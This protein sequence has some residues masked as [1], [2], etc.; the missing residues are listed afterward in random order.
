M[1]ERVNWNGDLVIIGGGA[2]GLA[3]AISAKMGAPQCRIALIEKNSVF[4]KKLRITGNGRGNISNSHILTAPETVAFFHCIAIMTRTD[5]AG[6]IYPFSESAAEMTDV[7]VRQAEILGCELY[8]DTLVQKV[9]ANQEGFVIQTENIDFKSSKLIIATGGKAGIPSGE[10]QKIQGRDGYFFAAELGHKL[11]KTTPVLTGVEIEDMPEILSGIRVKGEVRLMLK[12]QVEP[13]FTEKG[14]IQFT[15]YGLSGICIFNL[16]RYLKY[17]EDKKL[18]PYLILIDLDPEHEAETF[19]TNSRRYSLCCQKT[20]KEILDGC[21]KQQIV[22]VLLQQANTNEDAV[23]GNLSD[24]AFSGLI[25]TMHHFCF[26]PKATKGFRMAQCTAG[27]VSLEDLDPLNGASKRIPG[28]YIVGE[29]M[30][31]DGPCG[32]YNLDHAFSTGRL[33]GLDA[34]S[35]LRRMA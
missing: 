21:F 19:F 30:D 17:I 8:P 29:L 26:Q 16:S 6:R 13:L 3:A 31:Y 1:A 24:E 27:G 12:G 9:E 32:G 25:K 10:R 5:S 11:V 20:L 7:M 14:E 33:A 15:D 18:S 2:S 4:G 23:F 35:N 28:L 22:R 34:V